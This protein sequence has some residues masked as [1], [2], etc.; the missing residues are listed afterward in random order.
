MSAVPSASSVQRGQS[1]SFRGHWADVR[2]LA[3]DGSWAELRFTLRD[4]SGEPWGR[5]W[6]LP[7]PE[8]F[9]PA[10]E[11][12]APLAELGHV[13]TDWL[14]ASATYLSED[15]QPDPDAAFAERIRAIYRRREIED[16]DGTDYIVSPDDVFEELARRR[17]TR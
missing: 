13:P 6:K 3:R 2:K 5:R 15:E 4:G 9:R 14:G 8:T 17:M 7:L 10:A 16:R 1:F 12:L 11:G